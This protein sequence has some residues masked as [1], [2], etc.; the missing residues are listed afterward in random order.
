MPHRQKIAFE[1]IPQHSR[2]TSDQIIPPNM[3]F[4]AKFDENS[5]FSIKIAK[6]KYFFKVF[7]RKIRIFIKFG[8][9]MHVWVHNLVQ[10]GSGI[11]RNVFRSYFLSAGHAA[12]AF[13]GPKITFLYFLTWSFFE[14]VSFRR[15][16]DF[17]VTDLERYLIK[18]VRMDHT[19]HFGFR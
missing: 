10:F 14:K 12:G 6:K 8:L 1:H 7:S 5:D 15:K 11:L 16:L 3:H 19:D 4:Y 9:K 18:V 13:F 17:W 2:P